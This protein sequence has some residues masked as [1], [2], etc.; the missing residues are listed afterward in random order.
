MSGVAV[1]LRVTA[2]LAKHW[3]RVAVASVVS[4]VRST[5]SSAVSASIARL[6]AVRQQ[7]LDPAVQLRGQPREHVLQVGPRLMPVE[8]GRLQQTHHH[9]RALARQ[10]A[11][12]EQVIQDNGP[13]LSQFENNVFRFTDGRII[14]NTSVR[15]TVLQKVVGQ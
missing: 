13:L 11:A 2:A 6:P 10:L 4:W 15:S 9:R 3:L 7:L 12:D 5:L 14:P 8:L 1:W